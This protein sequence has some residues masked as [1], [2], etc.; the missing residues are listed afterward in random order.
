MTTT[1]LKFSTSLGILLLSLTSIP[2]LRADSVGTEIIG[3]TPV[4]ADE[5]VAKST[6]LLTDGNYICTGS[7]LD[8]DIVVTAAH[9]ISSPA[10]NI[11]V[12]FSLSLD[13]SG[14]SGFAEKP[15]G[16]VIAAVAHPGWEGENSYGVDQHDIGLIR[17]SGGLPQGYQPAA[18]LSAQ[19]SQQLSKGTEVILAGYG[20]TNAQ[21]QEGAGVLREVSVNIKGQLGKTE[22]V[23]DQHQGK[24]AC[25]GDS[26]GP[27]FVN[28]NGQLLLWGITNRGYPDNAPDDCRHFSV[29]TR[30]QAY[31]DWINTTVTQLR[32]QQR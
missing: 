28:E 30:I 21:T 26:G 18:L 17:F 13:S 7:I 29:Y 20:I 22:V 31:A 5:S 8:S 16:Q 2:S 1:Q 12:V 10:E 23:L 3:G 4:T 14:I 32:N 6:V 11:R 19:E 9:C 27:A 24:G 15:V 25:H